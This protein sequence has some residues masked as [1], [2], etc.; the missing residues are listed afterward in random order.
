MKTEIT[1]QELKEILSRRS[2]RLVDIREHYE[3]ERGTLEGAI[4]IPFRMLR[5]FPEK[6]L[7]KEEIYYLFCGSGIHSVLLAQKLRPLGY[8]IV[9][10]TDGFE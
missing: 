3:Y 4:N 7:L 5:E 6:Y 10:V 9:A 2:I 1:M 8:Q